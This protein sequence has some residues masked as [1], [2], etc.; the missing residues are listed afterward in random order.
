MNLRTKLGGTGVA[1]ITPFK[2]GSQET[3]FEALGRLIDYVIEGGVNYV[4]ALGTTG[5]TPTLDKAEKQAIAGFTVEKVNRRVPVVLGVGGNNTRE[6]IKELELYSF[7]QIT[8]ILS[9]SPMYNKPSQEGIYQHYK[10]FAQS[11]PVPV[12]L[13]NVPGRTGRNMEAATT[14]RLA[15]E[16]ENIGGI[17]EAGGDM[18]QSMELIKGRPKDFL[19]TSGDDQLAVAQIALGFDG[20]ISVAGQGVPNQF[21]AMIAAALRYDMPQAQQYLYHLLPL[22]D[23]LFA[24]NNPAGIKALLHQR[25][26][27]QQD[28]RLPVVPV[29]EKLYQSLAASAEGCH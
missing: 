15:R 7:D 26:I 19:V 25:G 6:L 11:A 22:M 14:L 23:H 24:E 28:T 10:M 2:Q 9:A 18:A 21:C 29:S 8:A 16:I 4:V 1:L 13:Y 27:A 12:I 17:K 5:E 20:V 3:D